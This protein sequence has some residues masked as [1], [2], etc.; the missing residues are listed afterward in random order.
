[1]LVDVS[2]VWFMLDAKKH[3]HSLNT[4]NQLTHN[5]FMFSFP[6]LKHRI[7]THHDWNLFWPH[8]RRKLKTIW[9]W[10]RGDYRVTTSS[11]W[12]DGWWNR[13]NTSLGF[14]CRPECCCS[15]IIKASLCNLSV[16]TPKSP[17]QDDTIFI[18]IRETELLIFK[19]K[20]FKVLFVLL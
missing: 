7:R 15:I 12:L 16:N 18:G 14:F 13:C 20:M 5:L 9:C 19:V 8:R 4:T 6:Y 2:I 10:A 17:I 11:F 3:A 1:M